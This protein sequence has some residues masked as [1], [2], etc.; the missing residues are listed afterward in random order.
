MKN[1]MRCILFIGIPCI[2]F[3]VVLS[4]IGEAQ[5]WQWLDASIA[6]IVIIAITAILV[7]FY[8]VDTHSIAKITERELRERIRPRI[9]FELH[10]K[11]TP[12]G[13]I[14]HV[15]VTNNSTFFCEVYTDFNMQVYDIPVEYSDRYTGREVWY[16]LPGHTTKG[17]FYISKIL[18]KA[19]KNFSQV[20]KDTNYDEAR[21][22]FIDVK[23]KARGVPGGSVGY[24][25]LHWYFD[26]NRNKWIYMS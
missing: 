10:P 8:V 6:N 24:P 26:F 3:F 14:T 1:N 15:F 22:L 17:Y 18:Q 23:I 21:K 16:I 25:K 19:G 2:V 12:S 13:I 5:E 4:S 7:L 9:G 20:I 11:K